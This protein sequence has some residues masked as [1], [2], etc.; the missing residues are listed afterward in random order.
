[1]NWMRSIGVVIRTPYPW[2]KAYGPHIFVVS[3][4]GVVLMFWLLFR[5]ETA[6]GR[7]TAST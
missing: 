3:L 5:V 4:A 1:M 7:T 6:A 2:V